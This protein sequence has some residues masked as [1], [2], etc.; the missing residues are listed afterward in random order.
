MRYISLALAIIQ[1]LV[2][3]PLYLKY[4]PVNIYSFWLATGNV[5][6]WLSAT[7]PGLTA[8]LQQQVADAYGQKDLTRVRSLI[9]GGLLFCIVVLAIALIFGFTAS[10]YLPELL[11]ITSMEDSDL[12]LGAFTLAIIG[13]ALMIFSFG[14]SAINAGLQGSIIVGLINISVMI[15]S[16]LVTYTLLKFGFG[17]MALS[18]SLLFSGICYSL[19]QGIYLFTRV[20]KEKIGVSFSFKGMKKLAKLL[21][22]TFISRTLGTVANNIDLIVVSR[23]LGPESVAILALTRRSVDMSKELINQPIA[24]FQPAVSH[25][26]G[27]GDEQKL[28]EILTRLTNILIWTLFLVVGGLISFNESFVNLWVGHQF[29]AGK[30]INLIICISIIFTMLYNG[31]YQLCFA[32][33]DV[34]GS[35]VVIGLQSALSI[36]IVIV[37]TKYFGMLGAVLAT[38]L[39]SLMVSIWYFPHKFARLLKLSKEDIKNI[40]N[41]LF[42]CLIT[43]LF[44]SYMVSFFA[45][46]SWVEF[47]IFVGFYSIVYAT[48]LFTLSVSFRREVRFFLNYFPRFK[49]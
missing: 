38:I 36:P 18:I 31:L 3:V 5:L 34:K 29:F 39:P 10:Y 4:I 6:A 8:V 25:A 44:M 23:F 17:L 43:I 47:C 42:L 12:I 14:I 27:E 7:D 37:A 24:A 15:A 26:K 11:N 20:Y 46:T 30:T 35:S 28:S 32:L 45:C 16:I 2:M 1:G 41:E 13:T 9:G 19:F 40:I 22:Y 49:R 21:S 33:G 48:I